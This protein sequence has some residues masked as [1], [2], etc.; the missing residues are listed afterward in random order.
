MAVAIGARG[1]SN[2][3]AND[4][5]VHVQ[6]EA[7]ATC[8]RLGEKELN[9]VEFKAG[10]ETPACFPL[11]QNG[12]GINYLVIDLG[13]G[14]ADYATHQLAENDQVKE[15]LASSGGPWGSTALDA[16]FLRL[17]DDI[18]GEDVLREF[19]VC[20]CAMFYDVIQ[21]RTRPADYVDMLDDWDVVKASVSM[22]KK[23][24]RVRLPSELINLC[25]AMT[26]KDV[27]VLVEE[28][29]DRLAR[30]KHEEDGTVL[31]AAPSSAEGASSSEEDW[32]RVP[33]RIVAYN[34]SALKISH[35][36]MMQR[37]FNPTV[38]QICAHT[39]KLLTEMRERGKPGDYVFLVG[40]FSESEVVRSAMERVVVDLGM[41]TSFCC[42]CHFFW[43]VCICVYTEKE[44]L[45]RPVHSS[46]AVLTGAVL[47]GLGQ[48]QVV[49]RVLK[50]TYG[51]ECSEVWRDDTHGK[52]CVLVGP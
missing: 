27:S 23:M 15:I 10:S 16:A 41:S 12:T 2:V 28:F 9:K 29:A 14:T 30:Q 34:H 32:I 20:H 19:Q 36:L 42:H 40:G 21:Q 50:K 31:S 4:W 49:G 7:G 38:S 35:E 6:P 46:L 43:D 22:E 26:K 8:C 24:R 18:V 51:I 5:V 25:V 37:I 39:Q 52:V 11:N 48:A 47:S 1:N 45:I 3:A 33:S 13:G 44:C 17:L